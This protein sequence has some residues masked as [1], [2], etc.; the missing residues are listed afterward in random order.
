MGNFAENVYYI[1]SVWCEQ[2]RVFIGR[3]IFVY[4][5]Q[6]TSA[7]FLSIV[8]SVKLS[9]NRRDGV[10]IF[11]FKKGLLVSWNGIEK[12]CKLERYWKKD[13]KWPIIPAPFEIA[14]LTFSPKVFERTSEDVF[15][16]IPHLILE[17]EEERKWK[18]P[19]QYTYRLHRREEIFVSNIR[20]YWL[21]HF[22]SLYL[23]LWK[24][25]LNF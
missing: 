2:M 8:N 19:N 23:P 15:G 1:I 18:Q 9:N 5:F 25:N 24:T 20:L 17:E 10:M 22:K 16:T 11:F 12:N 4:I 13:V 21:L 14:R 3:K 6:I 7:I